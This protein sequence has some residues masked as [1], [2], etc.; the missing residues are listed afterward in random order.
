MDLK[1]CLLHQVKWAAQKFQV[2]REHTNTG[3]YE[4][5]HHLSHALQVKP[6][7]IILNPF[8]KPAAFTT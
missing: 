4:G 2:Q 3:R 6:G 8:P 7:Y 5:N 1:H